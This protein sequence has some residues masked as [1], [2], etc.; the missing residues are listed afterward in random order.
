VVVVVVVVVVMET[1]GCRFAGSSSS[2][3]DEWK[4]FMSIT[5]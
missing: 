1:G 4:A 3:C 2:A 5:V